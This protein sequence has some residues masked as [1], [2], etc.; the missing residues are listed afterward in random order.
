MTAA[1]GF[2]TRLDAVVI[3]LDAHAQHFHGG[4]T[5]ADPRTGDR[6]DQGQVWAHLAEFIPYW[7]VQM[8]E[9]LSA[10]EPPGFGRT[11]AD[12]HRL[13]E[14]ERRRQEAPAALMLT[15]RQESAAL[16]DLLLR[17]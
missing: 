6:W 4:L 11:A 9:I 12:T 2:V 8:G 5:D 7:I 3:R 13:G 10:D 17:L 1:G 15:V 14:I 16:R